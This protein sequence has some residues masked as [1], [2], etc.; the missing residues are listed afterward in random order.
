VNVSAWK[1][2]LK[3]LTE[4]ANLAIH[5]A[6]LALVEQLLNV[7]LAVWLFFANPILLSTLN[8]L[9]FAFLT[10]TKMQEETA[11]SVIKHVLNVWIVSYRAVLYVT[12]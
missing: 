11:L 7:P 3:I 8:F 10:T 4:T 2:T 9:A 1:D 12:A 6:R 5:L